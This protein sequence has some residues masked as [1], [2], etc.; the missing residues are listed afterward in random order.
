MTNIVDLAMFDEYLLGRLGHPPLNAVILADQRRL[1]CTVGPVAIGELGLRNI[2]P[3]MT[4][5][6]S[7]RSEGVWTHP[8]AAPSFDIG[9]STSDRLGGRPTR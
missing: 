2:D 7:A 5:R 3:I 1:A 8:A 9:T 6:T 4:E